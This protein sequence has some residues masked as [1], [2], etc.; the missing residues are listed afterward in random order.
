MPPPKA[1]RSSSALAELS[2]QLAGAVETAANS[3][4]AIHARRRIPSSGIVWRDGVV[5]SASHTVKSDA[6]IPISL[7]SGE[8]ATASV[9]GRDPATDVVA[10]KITGTKL[11]QHVVAR[12]EADAR[13]GTLALAVGRPGRDVS[14]SFGIVSAVSEGWRTWQ[15]ARVDRVLRLDL[16]VYDGFSGGALADASGA[17]LG[18]NNSA[19]ARGAPM[20]LPAA[21][22]DRIVDELLASGHVRRPFIGVAVHPVAVSAG[23]AKQH[24]IEEGSALLVMS[25]ADGSPADRAGIAVGDVLVRSDGQPLR[26]PTDLLDAL[27]GVR[28]GASIRVDLLRGGTITSVTVTPSDRGGR[29]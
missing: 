11:K 15:G 20:S 8:R 7:P 21:A 26:R 19:L 25:V 4:V 6:E 3:I 24:T 22:V 5:V 9:A 28:S 12:A 23:A 18:L 13:V 14:A 29:E 2:S 10:L 27:S 1:T 16:A 17:V